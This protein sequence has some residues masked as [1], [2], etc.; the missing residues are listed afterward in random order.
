MTLTRLSALL[1]LLAAGLCLAAA[2]PPA[3]AQDP[4]SAVAVEALFS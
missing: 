4:E 1:A 2:I 3:G